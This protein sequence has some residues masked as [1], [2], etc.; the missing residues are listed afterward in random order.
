MVRASSSLTHEGWVSASDLAEYSY[1]PRAL[2]YRRHPPAE[3]PTP[4]SVVRAQQGRA[5]HDRA[6]V[7]THEREAHLGRYIGL[8]A[9]GVALALAGG[10]W[11]FLR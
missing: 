1:C 6:L 2:Y 5:R 9:L 8:T 4:A 11:L 3:G 10:L 7:R